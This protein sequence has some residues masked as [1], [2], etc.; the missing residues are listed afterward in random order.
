V[1]ESGTKTTE[2]SKRKDIVLKIGFIIYSPTSDSP[3]PV[4][5]QLIIKLKDNPVIQ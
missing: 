5:L 4:S 1:N 3:L 2:I